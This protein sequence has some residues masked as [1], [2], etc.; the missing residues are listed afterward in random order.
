MRET[1]N[2]YVCERTLAKECTFRM[3]RQI[4]KK[5]IPVEQA[6]K[7]IETGKTDLITKFI[8]SKT[9]RPFDAFLKLEKGKVGFEFPPREA[10]PGAKGGARGRFAK[11]TP[12]KADGEA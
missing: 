5:E 2:A 1:E 9:N 4:L 6:R 8:S 7:L 11:R 3:G 12:A 10:K